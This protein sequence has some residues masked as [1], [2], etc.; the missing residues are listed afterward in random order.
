[1]NEEDVAELLELAIH[2]ENSPELTDAVVDAFLSTNTECPPQRT[3]RV[4]ALFIQKIFSAVH[5]EPVQN[6]EQRWPFG[7]WIEATRESV[8]LTRDDIASAIRKNTTFVE[9]LEKGE[10]LPWRLSLIHIS[11]PTR[12]Y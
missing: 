12:P 11:E 4:R 10:D 6:I 2:A 1:M 5:C 7:R 8:R 9:R 3:E